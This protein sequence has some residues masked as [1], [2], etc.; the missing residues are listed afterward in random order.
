MKLNLGGGYLEEEIKLKEQL[1][2][3]IFIYREYK[4]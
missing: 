4:V 3:K 1:N 2:F